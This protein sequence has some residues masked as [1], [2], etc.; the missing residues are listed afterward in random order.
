MATAAA[1]SSSFRRTNPSVTSLGG[2]PATAAAAGVKRGPNAALY[3]SS[4]IPTLDAILGGGFLLGSLV[5]IVEDAEAPHHLL[6]LRNF[7]AQGLIHTQPLLFASSTVDPRAFMGTLPSPLSSPSS[8]ASSS[9]A[10]LAKGIGLRIA[11]QYRKYFGPQKDAPQGNNGDKKEFSCEFDLRKPLDKHLLIGEHIESARV[12]DYPNLGSLLDHCCAFLSRLQK[13]DSGIQCAGRIV[14][15][16]LCAPQCGFSK[17]DWDMISFIRSLKAALRASNGVAVLSFPASV[18]PPSFSVRWKHLADTLLSVS[19][20]QD[21][22]KNLAQLLSGY[23]DMV[24]FL[25]VHKVAQLNTQVPTI[26]E[27]RTFSLKLQRRRSLVL[28]PLNQAPVSNGSDG[29]SDRS[30]GSCGSSKPSS[31]DF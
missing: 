22:D 29:S 21:E 7:M 27:A 15:Q 10:Q 25:K 20:I 6:L 30:S 28:E 31:V 13:N 16:S 14:I 26:P 9:S 5:M 3:V 17:L 1:G 4:G 11:W 12:Q 2:S 19:A 18:L 23:Q 24:G 8:S